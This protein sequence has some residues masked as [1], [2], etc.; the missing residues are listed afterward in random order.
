[1]YSKFRFCT[2]VYIVCL[3]EHMLKDGFAV[4]DLLCTVQVSVC[5]CALR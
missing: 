2:Y 5:V 1:M 3:S 4:I